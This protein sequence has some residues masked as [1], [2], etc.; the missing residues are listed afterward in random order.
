MYGSVESESAFERRRMVPTS[1][2]VCAMLKF[3][4]FYLS[5]K[6]G[7]AIPCWILSARKRGNNTWRFL[8]TQQGVRGFGHFDGDACLSAS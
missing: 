4:E 8:Y 5:Y 3:D 7:V 1:E 2:R 6:K